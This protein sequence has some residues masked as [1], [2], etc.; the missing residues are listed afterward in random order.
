MN[1]RLLLKA[2]WKLVEQYWT[3]I[4]IPASTPVATTRSDTGVANLFMIQ[5]SGLW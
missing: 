4:R 3:R 1:R 2:P 5:A